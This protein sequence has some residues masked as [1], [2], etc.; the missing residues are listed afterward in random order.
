MARAYTLHGDRLIGTCPICGGIENFYGEMRTIDL[1]QH[2]RSP[3]G[4]LFITDQQIEMCPGSGIGVQL[5]SPVGQPETS[6]VTAPSDDEPFPFGKHQGIRYG[7]VPADY[8]DWAAGQPWL[9]KFSK[10]A[11]YIS[12][13]R[14]NIDKDLEDAGKI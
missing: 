9:N 1:P 14:A 3:R 4:Q 2:S 5:K 6:T 8:L 7:D 13:N 10:V 11:A 12:K